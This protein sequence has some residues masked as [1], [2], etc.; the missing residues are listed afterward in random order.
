[1]GSDAIVMGTSD[2]GLHFGAVS[3]GGEPAIAGSFVRRG[4]SE[5]ESRS[6]GFF[7]K[8][9]SDSFGIL[10]LPI[11][12][13]AIPE[14]QALFDESASIVFVRN[15]SLQL[16]EAGELAA[17]AHKAVEDDCRVSCVDWYGNARP[18]FVDDRIFALLG[19]EL[20]EGAFSEYRLREVRRV[21]F[22]PK[23][24]PR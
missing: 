24:E 23:S 10:G 9:E 4:A 14:R 3:L 6:H 20:V 12:M 2:A 19:Y 22:Q 7:Y 21:S 5:G 13:P 1:M 18:L 11:L 8:S 15:Q 17:H 16:A